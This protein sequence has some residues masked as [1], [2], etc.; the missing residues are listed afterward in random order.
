M[1][2]LHFR[3]LALFMAL[4]MVCSVMMI[5]VTAGAEGEELLSYEDA[6]ASLGDI[7]PTDTTALTL[8][9]Q[10]FEAA[11]SRSFASPYK[12]VINALLQLSQNG[13]V[14]YAGIEA[15]MALLQ[16]NPAFMEL[17]LE[18]NIKEQLINF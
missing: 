10:S 7:S 18:L 8:L 15:A 17:F 13:N 9:Y 4:C 3:G 11:G 14:D 5:P 6:V 2:K 1:K 16:N 12:Y